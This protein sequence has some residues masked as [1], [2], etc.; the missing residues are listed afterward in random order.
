MMHVCVHID[1]IERQ[2]AKQARCTTSSAT[3]QIITCNLQLQLL[4]RCSCSQAKPQLHNYK[5]ASANHWYNRWFVNNSD[6]GWHMACM[7]E[8][9]R[10]VADQLAGGSHCVTPDCVLAQ[11]GRPSGAWCIC[12]ADCT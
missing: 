5:Q 6:D 11:Y 12:Q 8:T 2:Y 3:V 10:V 4:L 1:D 7:H 9:Y